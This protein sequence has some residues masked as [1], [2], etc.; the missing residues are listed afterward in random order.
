MSHAWASADP[1]PAGKPAGS[2]SGVPTPSPGG[3]RAGTL[4]DNPERQRL[5]L[6]AL[7]GVISAAAA[8]VHALESPLP[9]LVPW[10]KPGLSHVLILFGIVRVSPGFGAA[11]VLIRSVLSG[12]ALG[13]LLS[14]ANLLGLAGGLAAVAAM[15]LAL[16]LGASIL[17]LA[18][19]SVLGAVAN[20]LAQ[21]TL[22]GIWAGTGLPLGLHLLAL[23]W[24]SIPSGLLVAVI[25]YELF[26][27]TT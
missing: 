24:V 14:P 5:R 1:F 3:D 9:R 17:G 11:V 7:L 25:A 10:L 20:N 4:P 12:L 6:I 2:F 27:R 13:L 18:G 8:A 16:R 22:V 19:I 15:T 23:I 21:L 26:R